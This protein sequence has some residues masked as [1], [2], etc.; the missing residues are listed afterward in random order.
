MTE[1]EQLEDDENYKSK[2]QIK[3]EV[4]ALQVIGTKLLALSKQQQLKVEMSETLRAALLEATRIKQREAMRRH[5]QY[6]GRIM[7]NEDHEAIAARIALFDSSSA[8]HNKLFHSLESQRDSL[9]GENSA[10]EVQKYLKENPSIDI[11]HFRQLVRQSIKELAEGK[12]TSAR[13]KL[14]KYLREIK[15]TKL[16]INL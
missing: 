13:K 2:T 8:A 11:Q 3:R 12:K 16:G 15:E 14:F 7:R 1:F 6:I 9:I 5:M 4:E 10:T